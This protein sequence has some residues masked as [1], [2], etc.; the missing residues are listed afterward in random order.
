MERIIVNLAKVN[1]TELAKQTGVPLEH[2]GKILE[3]IT[4]DHN[5]GKR[6]PLPSA[7]EGWISLGE[8][9][10]KYHILHS[11]LSRWVNRFGIPELNPK[12]G[13]RRYVF[14]VRLAE[15]IEKYQQNP[16]KGKRTL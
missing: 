4:M 12:I 2:V 5:N 1:S 13:N 8:A 14:E 16:G 6:Q 11:T 9:E 10:R 3:Q 15:L 7:P